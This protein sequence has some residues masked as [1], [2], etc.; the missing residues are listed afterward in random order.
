M[1]TAPEAN[2]AGLALFKQGKYIE[3]AK[4]FQLGMDLANAVKPVQARL[5]YSEACSWSMA[6]KFPEA[7]EALEQSFMLGYDDFEGVR[8]DP[9]L[10]NLREDGEPGLFAELLAS[11]EEAAPMKKIV[12]QPSQL[13]EVTVWHNL[14]FADQM[15]ARR[16]TTGGPN[17]V[18]YMSGAAMAYFKL[19]PDATPATLER[20]L[21]KRGFDTGLIA[22][23]WRDDPHLRPLVEGGE[24]VVRPFLKLKS[25]QQAAGAAGASLSSD[26]YVMYSCRPRQY[27]ENERSQHSSSAEENLSRL[28]T[29]GDLCA[30]VD[31]PTEEEEKA[32]EKVDDSESREFE[33]GFLL[34]LSEK[35]IIHK[36]MKG[37]AKLCYRALSMES[38]WKKARESHP[39]A[40]TVVLQLSGGGPLT[41]LAEG[42][43]IIYL[44][45]RTAHLAR[46]VA[47]RV[48]V[49]AFEV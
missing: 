16:C 9:D 17:P 6:H 37:E 38:V 42:N 26:Y 36:M 27:A 35:D 39:Q 5:R 47:A 20:E 24:V 31:V 8:M 13:N 15:I 23:S 34:S 3:A 19:Y 45:N 2:K 1:K 21:R 32:E 25:Q 7:M 12:M 41:A 18:P 10:K 29:A 33:R 11:Q 49:R 40:K 4:T 44:S 22:G 43:K 48:R 28:E 14:T 46:A 30:N